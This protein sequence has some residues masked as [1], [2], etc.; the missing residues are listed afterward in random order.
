MF[1]HC[2]FI[3]PTLGVYRKNYYG[4]HCWKVNFERLP[5]FHE[6]LSKSKHICMSWRRERGFLIRRFSHPDSEQWLPTDC[7]VN[8]SLH[9]LQRLQS[10]QLVRKCKRQLRDAPNICAKAL[11]RNEPLFASRQRSTSCEW[12]TSRLP[13]THRLIIKRWTNTNVYVPINVN[14]LFALHPLLAKGFRGKT[15][16]EI[17]K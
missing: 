2:W 1:C 15:H 17:V 16:N 6:S 10:S 13:G 4:A 12:S 7:S 9:A 3:F 5:A 11:R 14:I 8:I